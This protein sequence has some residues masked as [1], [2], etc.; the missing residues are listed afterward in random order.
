MISRSRAVLAYEIRSSALGTRHL[1]VHQPLTQVFHYGLPSF[2]R[3]VSASIPSSGEKADTESGLEFNIT[4]EHRLSLD[5][6]SPTSTIDL[7]EEIG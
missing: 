7:R 4:W 1:C 6:G 5:D 2:V 3:F